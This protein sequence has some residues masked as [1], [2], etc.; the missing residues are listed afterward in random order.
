[1][2]REDERIMLERD[3]IRCARALIDAQE[4]M[5]EGM[6][7]LLHDEDSLV[8]FFVGYL[9]EFVRWGH[10]PP[11]MPD[12]EGYM[13]NMLAGMVGQ[14]SMPNKES[15]VARIRAGVFR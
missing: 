10:E 5:R 8:A 4:A 9:R 2:I 12:P 3:G 14:L 1:M 11:V 6:A 13:E 7:E 15:L